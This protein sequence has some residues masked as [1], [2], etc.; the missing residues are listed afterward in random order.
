YFGQCFYKHLS[1]NQFKKILEESDFY[2]ELLQNSRFSYKIYRWLAQKMT[3]FVQESNWVQLYSD[4][5][6]NLIEKVGTLQNKEAYRL[7]RI[8]HLLQ[9][10][11]SSLT[12]VYISKIAQELGTAD[13][14]LKMFTLAN[15]KRLL[16]EMLAEHLSNLEQSKKWEGHAQ[17]FVEFYLPEENKALRHNVRFQW[18]EEFINNPQ[19]F[20]G[21]SFVERSTLDGK[22]HYDNKQIPNDE[23]NLAEFYGEENIIKVRELIM[24]RLDRFS[25]NLS[26]DVIQLINAYYRDP[27]FNLEDDWP[28]FR[29]KCDL[30]Q[31]AQRLIHCFK[32]GLFIDGCA[33]LE[34]FHAELLGMQAL[35]T[36][37]HGHLHQQISAY[38][39][40]LFNQILMIVKESYSELF[41]NQRLIEDK[42]AKSELSELK[43]Q[44]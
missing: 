26:D 1:D 21:M 37:E 33:Q 10:N 40:Q 22:Y 32:N 41:I 17:Y 35:A 16:S 44:Q 3:E 14:S 39:Q 29:K 9:L 43:K 2:S 6:F 36:A 15:S 7:L 24:N 27:A 11:N 30:F 34:S 42:L 12:E 28:L 38:Q 4:D 23:V 20:S 31:R 5:F 19:K 25:E 13:L 8:K 18:L